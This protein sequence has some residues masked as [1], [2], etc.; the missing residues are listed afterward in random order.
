MRILDKYILKE[1]LGP[2]FFGIAAFSSV[3]IGTST[4]F[5]I[6]QYVTKYGASILT[7]TKLFFYSLPGIIVLTFPM[8]MLL[9]AL[10]AFGRLSGSSE[11]TAMRSG[12]LSFY[13]LAVPVMITALV[14]SCAAIVLN[15]EV[16]PAAN[17]G[18]SNIVRYEIEKN[19]RT[20][21]QEHIVV[22]DVN[23]AG[24]IERLTY[25]QNYMSD[26]NTLSKVSVQEFEAGRLVRL[27]NAESAVW[28]ADRWIMYNGT[29]TDL[30][31]EGRVTRTLKFTEQVMPITKNPTD[32]SREQK[33]PDEMSM[34]ELKQYISVLKKEYAKTSNYEVELYQRIAIPMASFVFA[35][36][37]TPL[38]LS[39]NRSSSSIGLGLSIIIIFMYY[40]VLTVC[41]AL[42]Q[43]GAIPPL[44]AAWIPNIIGT[45]AGIYLIYKAS[46]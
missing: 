46:R 8:S 45:L 18:Y 44:L 37:G 20:K 31:T 28:A 1:L 43:G 13:R 32:I 35:L 40:A 16:V 39:P 38:G 41:T 33:K 26:T 7:V 17:A 21:S 15:E 6:A 29:I 23:K 5:R 19:T 14:V 3:F 24:Q 12:G 42:G 9:A 36:I 34:A 4:L 10:L 22:K 11:I 27:E 25:A 2:F 30:S